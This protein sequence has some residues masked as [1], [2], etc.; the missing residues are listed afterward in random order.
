[1]TYSIVA[2]DTD[3]GR[4]GVAAQSCYFALGSVLPWARAGV[5]AVASMAVQFTGAFFP[6]ENS[7][8]QRALNAQL[9]LPPGKAFIAAATRPA[10]ESQVDESL[11]NW[12]NALIPDAVH[13]LV[14]DRDS[15]SGAPHYCS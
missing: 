14:V 6:A 11:F 1:M 15:R 7:A 2:R 8:A 5:G 12:R 4:M 9:N 10:V 13:Q 3:S